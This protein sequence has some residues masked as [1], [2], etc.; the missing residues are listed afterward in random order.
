MTT[1]ACCWC[2]S[3]RLLNLLWLVI[4]EDEKSNFWPTY[5]VKEGL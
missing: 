3:D 2:R 5:V 4:A 1:L